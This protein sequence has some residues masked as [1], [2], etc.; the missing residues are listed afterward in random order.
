M[1]TGDH[2]GLLHRSQKAETTSLMDERISKIFY[3]LTTENHPG[4]KRKE[5]LRH[6]TTGVNL[7]HIVTV[8]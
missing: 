3:L 7:E 6:V 4:L 5:S 2:S 8:V 1:C